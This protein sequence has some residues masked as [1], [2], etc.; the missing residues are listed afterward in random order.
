MKII[1]KGHLW[2]EVEGKN[3]RRYSVSYN[4]GLDIAVVF[5]M[6]NRDIKSFEELPTEYT[7]YTDL[8]F[9]NYY[10]IGGDNSLMDE[11][12]MK[13]LQDLLENDIER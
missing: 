7:D 13:W 3:S 10:H 11:D 8:E 2:F 9:V 5:E 6:I 1:N 12:N 4:Y